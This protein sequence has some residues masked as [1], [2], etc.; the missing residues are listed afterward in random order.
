MHLLAVLFADPFE[1]F[2]HEGVPCRRVHI[3]ERSY[4]DRLHGDLFQHTWSP[5]LLISY[6]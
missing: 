3:L 6:R 4:Y 5:V 1:Q 2:W